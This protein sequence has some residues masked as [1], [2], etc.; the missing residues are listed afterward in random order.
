MDDTSE[1]I[2]VLRARFPHIKG[3]AKKDICYATTNRQDAVKTIA[4]RCDG[5]IVIG[6]PNSSNSQ[7]LVEVAKNKGCIESLL[8]ER[9]NDI[10]WKWIGNKNT[11]GITAGASAPEL[12]VEEVIREFRK[13]CTITI[14]EVTI[15]KEE[16][17]FKLPQV[18]MA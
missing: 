8:I 3:P 11:L 4:E 5:L 13:R 10:D 9:V 12:L 6:A 14:E 2:T 16:L 1:I 17:K 15:A 7:R 18:L